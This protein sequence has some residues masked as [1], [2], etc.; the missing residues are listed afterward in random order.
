MCSKRAMSGRQQKLEYFNMS[1]IHS[2]DSGAITSQKIRKVTEK[3]PKKKRDT[4]PVM[5]QN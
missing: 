3:Y 1:K 2:S 4:Y 5:N